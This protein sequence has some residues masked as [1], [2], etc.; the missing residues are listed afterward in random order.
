MD[1]VDR[2]LEQIDKWAYPKADEL[3]ACTKAILPDVRSR[4]QAVDLAM[5]CL[6]LDDAEMWLICA[7]HQPT[8]VTSMLR[9]VMRQVVFELLDRE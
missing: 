8:N 3:V 6:G 2:L 1:E 9:E 7:S 4:D 5:K